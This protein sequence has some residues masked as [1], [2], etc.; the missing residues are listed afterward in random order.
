M[1]RGTGSC[2]ST[3]TLGVMLSSSEFTQFVGDFF[4]AFFAEAKRVVA[5][6]F[7]IEIVVHDERHLVLASE[8]RQV[9]VDNRFSTVKSGTKVLTLFDAIQ[10]I[11][12]QR[13]HNDDGP[14][15]WNV[16]LY[17]NWHSRVQIGRTSDATEASIVA[18]HLST[19]TGKKV[20][21]L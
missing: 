16:S 11:D 7:A 14:E 17:I 5:P 4:R 8:G 9:V 3:Q 13:Q 10:S 20:L 21:A 18:A 15:T 12:I 1:P 2:R 19:I 6:N